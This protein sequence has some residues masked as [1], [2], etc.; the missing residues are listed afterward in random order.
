[1]CFALFIAASSFFM[2]EA[3]TFP[4]ALRQPALLAVPVLLPLLAMPYWIW[5][6]RS[7][8]RKPAPVVLSASERAAA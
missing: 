7:R 4:E 3:H 5:R 8:K 6:L 2:G 1:M